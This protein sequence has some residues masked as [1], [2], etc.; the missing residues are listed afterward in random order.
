M[1]KRLLLVF[2]VGSA[3]ALVWCGQNT[4]GW[5]TT[6]TSSKGTG[7]VAEFASCLTEKWMKMYG[8]DWCSHCQAAKEKF[9]DDFDKI[10]FINCDPNN[11]QTAAGVNVQCVT[12]GIQGYPTW[13]I[14]G[15]QYSGNQPWEVLSQA[16]GCPL[17][18]N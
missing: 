2:F 11:T 4:E 16:S 9:G 13:V 3:F 7:T 5:D 10:T 1:K 17:P 14:N 15:K 8:T 12:A 18:A 6:V